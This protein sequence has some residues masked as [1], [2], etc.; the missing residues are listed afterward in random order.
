M[1]L[2]ELFKGVMLDLIEWRK[3]LISGKLTLEQ[4]NELK[5]KITVKVDWGNGSV[6]F[7][8]VNF[9]AISLIFD[10]HLIMCSFC[11]VQNV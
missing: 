10:N 6:V 9:C 3:E 7:L 2:F 1:E 4:K 8:F 5:A 11:F